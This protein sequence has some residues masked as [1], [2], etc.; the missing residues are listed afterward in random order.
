MIFII[1]R[2]ELL[3]DYNFIFLT[4]KPITHLNAQTSN[5]G[6]IEALNYAS[7][8]YEQHQNNEN[9]FYQLFAE[10]SIFALTES[11]RN[12]QRKLESKKLKTYCLDGD[13][14]NGKGRLGHQEKGLTWYYDGEFKGGMKD[15]KGTQYFIRRDSVILMDHGSFKNDQFVFGIHNMYVQKTY[16]DRGF[17]HESIFYGRMEEGLRTGSGTLYH[18]Y[19]MPG[20]TLDDCLAYSFI[21]WF[22]TMKTI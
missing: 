12:H 9:A 11:M 17:H 19:G 6:K 8:A 13:C 3:P 14:Q 22:C 21:C 7:E 2:N 4:M 20:G 18:D 1:Y 15:G 16:G 5:V 10:F